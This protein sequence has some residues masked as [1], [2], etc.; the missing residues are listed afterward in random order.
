MRF[1][2]LINKEMT[3]FSALIFIASFSFADDNVIKVEQ[4]YP[5][6]V[7]IKTFQVDQETTV[8]IYGKGA[9]LKKRS[10]NVLCYGWIINAET[11][12]TEWNSLKILKNKFI[13][14]NGIFP[15]ED[16]V[17][18][19]PGVYKALY[20]AVYDNDGIVIK[21]FGDLMESIFNNWDDEDI[22]TFHEDELRM[23]VKGQK[24]R[25]AEIDRIFYPIQKNQKEVVS[26]YRV[27]ANEFKEK[28]FSLKADTKVVVRS[29]C[30]KKDRQ[31][32]DFG[33]IYDM[34]NHEVV[35]PTEETVFEYA[36]GGWKNVMT[37][38]ELVLSKGD[39]RVSFVSDDSHSFNDWNVLPPNN[40]E[41]WGIQ[42]L[43]QADDYRNIDFSIKKYVPVIGLVKV[44][45]NAVLSQGMELTKDLAIRVI[46]IGEYSSGDVYDY[47]WI[48]NAATAEIV[49]KFKGSNTT[50]AGGGEKNRK[51]NDIV[52]LPK[53]KYL[54]K[55][56]SDGSHSYED[57]NTTPPYEKEY[58]G[59]SIWTIKDFDRDFIKLVNQTS[60]EDENI[61]V[62][63]DKVGDHQKIVK[64]FSIPEDGLYRI[65]AI[66]EGDE[67]EMF[68]TG[69]IEN[70]DD[71][72]VVWELTWRNSKPA[73][74]ARKNRM[75]NGK[76][77]LSK[78]EYRAH[79]ITD[80]SHSFAGW[81]D[82]PPGN[83]EKYG[84][85]I[86]KD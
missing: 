3:L 34:K 30:E 32:Y 75:F 79:F 9:K 65:Y 14:E 51:F 11:G 5:G 54:V 57:W 33:R 71:E 2:C 77:Y 18:L 81:N 15:F 35:W 48:E 62:K 22:F 66:G 59:I 86:M 84:I 41:G 40:P 42:V 53:G 23:I 70:I 31:F 58:W 20:T 83:P 24:N 36:G 21:D 49:W 45:N 27:S 17:T 64:S 44:G 68:D 72:Q 4:I 19:N 55:Y 78:G 6:K 50:H 60:L 67:D 80:G 28:S 47:G 63:I 43:C 37:E 39:Y 29:I 61:I 12:R 1:K 7:D 38:E 74:G 85:R 82:N 8:D 73:G 69:W 76:I 52:E 10:R 25:F 13:D 26:F 16:Q 56:I 46:C